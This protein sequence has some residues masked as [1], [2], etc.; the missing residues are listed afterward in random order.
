MPWEEML[1]CGGPAWYGNRGG[2]ETASSG[3]P[4]A[5]PAMTTLARIRGSL[6]GCCPGATMSF[7][8][9]TRHF[10]GILRDGWLRVA[11]AVWAWPAL[12]TLTVVLGGGLPRLADAQTVRVT[13]D[14]GAFTIE[15][16]PDRAPLTVANFL[17][18]VNEGFYTNTLFH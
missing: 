12:L 16:Q 1:P 17:R 18:Y 8:V 11:R 13:T 5:R 3:V 6:M 9:R 15:L 7:S 10:M 2:P 4:P 14:M